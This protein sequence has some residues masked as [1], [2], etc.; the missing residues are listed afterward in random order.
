MRRNT[1]IQFIIRD[2]S[3]AHAH[4]VADLYGIE[5]FTYY[6]MR[7]LDVNCLRYRIDKTVKSDLARQQKRPIENDGR[8]T[9]IRK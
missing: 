2:T 1:A 3:Q 6:S 7:K 5:L 9:W 8:Q 4:K